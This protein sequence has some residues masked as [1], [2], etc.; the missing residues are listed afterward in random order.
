[1]GDRKLLSDIICCWCGVRDS[2]DDEN[3]E[4]WIREDEDN[5]ER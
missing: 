2:D 4:E 1:M 5:V 3:N